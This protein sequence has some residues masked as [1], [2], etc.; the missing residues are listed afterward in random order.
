P[1]FRL[2]DSL[3]LKEVNIIDLLSHRIGFET[4]QGDFTYWKSNLTRAQVIQKMGLIEAPYGFRSKW[5]YCNAAFV[6]AGE[7]I[8]RIIGRSWEETV[9]DSI[10][11]PLNMKRTLMLAEEL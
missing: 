8:P 4:F 6:T 2:K 5:G 1:E 11:V 7:I 10:L 9:K 3:A